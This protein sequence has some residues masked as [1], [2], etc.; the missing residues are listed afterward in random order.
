MS[1]FRCTRSGEKLSV[2]LILNELLA[3]QAISDNGSSF[4]EQGT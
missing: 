3:G 1:F 2:N 4:A